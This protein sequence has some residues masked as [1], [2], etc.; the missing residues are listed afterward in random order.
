MMNKETLL[1]HQNHIVLDE[2]SCLWKAPIEKPE[3]NYV[4][5]ENIL[6]WEVIEN[7]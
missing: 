7:G 1:F 2:E 4:W 5:N 6:N 3:G